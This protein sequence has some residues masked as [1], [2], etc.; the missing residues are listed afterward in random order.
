MTVADQKEAKA[1]RKAK[2]LTFQD[3]KDYCGNK[4]LEFP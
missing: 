4:L 2:Y 1:W 3:R